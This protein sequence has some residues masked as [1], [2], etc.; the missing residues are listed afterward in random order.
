MRLSLLGLLLIACGTPYGASEPSP[1]VDD[2]KTDPSD[3]KKPTTPP[4]TDD[5][6]PPK[7]ACNGPCITQLSAGSEFAC[8]LGDD[9]QVR[10]WGKN[11]KGQ[12]G[13]DVPAATGK[14]AI[15]TGLGT[16]KK[17]TTGNAHAC[18][19]EDTG[20]VKC[21]GDDTNGVVSGV[22]SPTARPRPTTVT[23]FPADVLTLAALS[24]SQCAILVNSELWCWGNNEYGQLGVADVK[25]IA[26]PVKTSTNVVQIGASEEAL[27]VRHGTGVLQCLGRNFS[28]TLGV[29][30]TDL[31]PH[32]T[33]MQVNG[34][35][36]VVAQ[37]GSGN[38]YH[39]VVA[40]DDG[41]VAAWGSNARNAIVPDAAVYSVAS[42]RAVVG[43]TDIAEVV[44]GGYFT[45]ARKKTDGSVLCWGDASS[46]QLGQAPKTDNLDPPTK[47]DGL[48]PVQ[49]IAA[50]R[51]GFACGVAA[52]V[53]YCWGANGSGE[54][55]RGTV[56]DPLPE[57]AA[58]AF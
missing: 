19:L 1:F 41:K 28:G 14:P 25:V 52:G 16:I 40:L 34:L 5:K 8:A 43:A 38:G 23:G 55:G 45:C 48:P 58:I 56:G 35:P 3:P 12:T 10:C 31:D 44:A 2:D 29:G 33:A 17:I 42:P 22:P 15:V 13:S 11:D 4:T 7:S 46:G 53:G 37:M 39:M 20:V 27:C 30:K 26:K 36:G 24:D 32:P 18:A 6:K 21:W 9:A 57:P 54:L 47:I 51:S 50:G 49:S